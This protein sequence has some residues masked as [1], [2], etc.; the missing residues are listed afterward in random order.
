MTARTAHFDYS[1]I[2]SDNELALSICIHVYNKAI[3]F[4]SLYSVITIDVWK[5]LIVMSI[6]VNEY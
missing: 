3:D 5:Y 1:F 2:M 6:R 4:L